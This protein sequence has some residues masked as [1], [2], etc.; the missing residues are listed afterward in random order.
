[1]ASLILLIGLPGSGKSYWVQ[2]FVAQSPGTPVI[3]T[4]RIRAQLFGDEAI[5]GSWQFVWRRVQSEFSHAVEQINL[6]KVPVAIYDAT[7]AAR[8]QRRNAIALAGSTGFTGITGVWFNT[9]LA[10]CLERNCR[11]DR[12]V[13]EAVILRMHRQLQDAPPALKEGFDQLLR[14]PPPGETPGLSLIH[15]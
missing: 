5:Q 10:V 9:P 14:H 2:Q 3:S 13:P 15:I 11:R 4:D 8:R 6:G 7:N 1:M 12:F